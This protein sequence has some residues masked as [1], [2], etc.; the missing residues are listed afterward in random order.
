MASGSYRVYYENTDAGGVVYYAN[1]LAFAERARADWLR[2]LGFEQS[3]LMQSKGI[4]FPVYHLEI[5]YFSP[6]KLDDLLTIDTQLIDVRKA[7]ISMNQL[8]TCDGK[9]I[10]SLDISI[11]CV[12]LE[13]K[14]TRWPSDLYDSFSS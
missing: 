12:D 9:K 1:Y 5:R 7:S 8:I 4:L 10:A 11:A 14:P 13:M 2:T 6:A 3:E